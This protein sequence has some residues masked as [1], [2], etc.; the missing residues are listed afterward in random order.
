MRIRATGRRDL[1]AVA[2]MMT[3]FHRH[4]AGMERKRSRLKLATVKTDLVRAGFGERSYFKGLVAEEG[5]TYCGY[6]LY[7]FGFNTNVRRASMVVSDL[8][9][10]AR[11]RRLKVGE[12]LMLRAREIALEHGCGHMEWMVWNMNPPA[13]AFY[14]G[15]GAKSVDDEILMGWKIGR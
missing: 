6:L 7:H 5:Q 8:F 14:L 1:D 13:I 15:L 3:E 2:T 12:A 4:L 9:V 10:R 11:W